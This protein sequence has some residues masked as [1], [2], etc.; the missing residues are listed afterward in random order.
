PSLLDPIR[1]HNRRIVSSLRRAPSPDV[2]LIAFLVVEGLR[3]LELFDTNPL[4]SA[5][6]EGVL[7][8]LTDALER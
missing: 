6:S 2:A 3:A 5:E 4:S 1:A 7:S 8:R